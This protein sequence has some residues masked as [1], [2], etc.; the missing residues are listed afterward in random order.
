LDA[1]ERRDLIDAQS[2]ALSAV[3]DNPEDEAWGGV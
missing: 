2:S 3:W 1:A